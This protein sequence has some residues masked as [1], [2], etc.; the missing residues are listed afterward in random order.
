MFV[1]FTMFL[2]SLALIPQ[3]YHIYVC[4]D[5]EGLNQYYL[6]CLGLARMGRVFFWYTMS[7][8]ADTFWYLMA[9]DV[10]HTI[11]LGLFFYLYRKVDLLKNKTLFG[12]EIE[13]A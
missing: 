9:A 1:S 10:L 4:K 12:M 11:L 7:S 13:T 8:K 5:T 2:E 6:Y 3:L